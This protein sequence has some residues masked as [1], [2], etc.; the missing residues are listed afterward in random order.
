MKDNSIKCD[1]CGCEMP[2]LTDM[3]GCIKA[4]Y[5]FYKVK[6]MKTSQRAE[7]YPQI[8]GNRIKELDICQN[9]M[10]QIVNRS[11]RK[12]KRKLWNKLVEFL[13]YEV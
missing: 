11:I 1:L 9:C 5:D 3:G 13:R 8:F 10:E 4:D 2:Y 7:A 6:V 12:R